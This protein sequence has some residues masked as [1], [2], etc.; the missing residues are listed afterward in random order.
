[1]SVMV[2]DCPR[3]GAEEIT[4]DVEAAVYVGQEY[5][6]VDHYEVFCKCRR[7]MRSTTFYLSLNDYD[8]RAL[9]RGTA[10]L[11]NAEHALDRYFKVNGYVSIKDHATRNPPDHI[12]EAIIGPFN[13]ASLCLAVGCYNAAGAMFRLCIDLA[14]SPLLPDPADHGVAQPNAKQRRDLGLRLAW[15]FEH[16][17]LD[18]NLREL[19]SCIREDGN[20]GAHSGT[21]SEDDAEDLFDF[22]TSLLE[23]QF[24]E[25]QRLRLAQE[26]RAARRMN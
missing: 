7:C 12:P 19:A 8:A 11:V 4:F 17:K 14:T 6:W 5:G 23:R 10:G 9:F 2:A 21:L 15:L 20:D 1:M 16:D 22:T 26:R 25:P 3:C 18:R 13:E 24:T